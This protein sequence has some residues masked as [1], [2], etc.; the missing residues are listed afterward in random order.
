MVKETLGYINL[1]SWCGKDA[2]FGRTWL[3]YAEHAEELLCGAL[4]KW[5]NGTIIQQG[6]TVTVRTKLAHETRGA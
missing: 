6:K 3:E 4:F 1:G 2:Y 5:Q